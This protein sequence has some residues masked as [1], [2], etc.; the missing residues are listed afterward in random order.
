MKKENFIWLTLFIIVVLIFGLSFYFMR[1]NNQR[2]IIP[3]NNVNQKIGSDNFSKKVECEKYKDQIIKNI[4][5]FNLSQKPEVRDGN[6][7]GTSDHDYNLYI[8]SNEFKEIFYSPKVNSC[9]YLGSRKTLIKLGANADPNKGNWDISYETYYLIDVLTNKE[10]DF[11]KGLPFLQ[12][13]SRGDQFI[14]KKDA[15]VIIND[16]R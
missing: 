1:T 12:I 14:S 13:I 2:I 15:D 3:K 6:N 11:N 8:E 5:Q 4:N 9:V 16:Y 7:N 10:I